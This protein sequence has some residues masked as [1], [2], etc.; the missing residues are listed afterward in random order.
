MPSR[1]SGD[2]LAAQLRAAAAAY[3]AAAVVPHC[4]QCS[5]PCCWLQ[6]QVL[7]LNWKQVKVF[8]KLD[9][10]R[11]AFD[12]RLAAGQGPQELRAGNGL[13]YAHRKTCP[14]YDPVQRNC[15]VYDQPLKP[16]GCSDYPVYEDGDCVVADQ[17]CEAVDIAALQAE[18]LQTLG[19][20]WRIVRSANPDFP[21]LITLTARSTRR[22]SA[23]KSAGKTPDKA[24]GKKRARSG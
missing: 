4:T 13:Y 23:G 21:F 9:E 3:Q 24:V 14:V 2:F 15:T 12:Q 1:K 5:Q 16:V 7:E 8:W 18:I 6:T 22:S 11:T 17:R 20:D 10:T 19:P